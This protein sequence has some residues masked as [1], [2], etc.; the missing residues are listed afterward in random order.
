[1][2]RPLLESK[3]MH[4]IQKKGQKMLKKIKIF[5]NLGKIV[6]NLKY[7]DKRQVIACDYCLQ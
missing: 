3:S 6:Q 4:V 1:M 5:E 7:L 2:S